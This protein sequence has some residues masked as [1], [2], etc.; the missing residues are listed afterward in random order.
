MLER[1]VVRLV[2]ARWRPEFGAELEGQVRAEEVARQAGDARVSGRLAGEFHVK[3]GESRE[4]LNREKR[5]AGSLF[6]DKLR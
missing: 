6:V 2:I 4:E 3:L 1:E 5:V